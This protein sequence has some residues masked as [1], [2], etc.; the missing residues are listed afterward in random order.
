MKSSIEMDY[1]SLQEQ[2]T[3]EM[4]SLESMVDTLREE[5]EVI[6]KS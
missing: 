4:D 5:R 6:W 2:T 3:S 1:Q